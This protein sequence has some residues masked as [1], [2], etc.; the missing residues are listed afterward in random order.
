MSISS[1]IDIRWD[2]E[3]SK[4]LTI[5][6]IK[7]FVNK[8]WTFNDYCGKMYLPLGD[9]DY[10]WHIDKFISDKD[11][12]LIL[13]SKDKKN[14][15]IGVVMTYS[16]T[17]IGGEFRFIDNKVYISLSINRKLILGERKNTDFNW[18]LNRIVPVFDDEEF[19]LLEYK[20]SS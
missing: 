2:K 8:G 9:E 11:L 13:E 20:V 1:Y 15:E 5:N 3:G 12:L 16:D 14:E 4:N 19:I 7:K 17:M 6:L 10:D 18:Y